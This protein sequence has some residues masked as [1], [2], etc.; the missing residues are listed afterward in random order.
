MNAI[1]RGDLVIHYTVSPGDP[2]DRFCPGE[3][4]HVEDLAV[5]WR[6]REL[7]NVS[8]RNVERIETEIMSFEADRW[9]AHNGW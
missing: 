1:E 5:E 7:V 6:G 2:G 8:N 9:E 3:P 4:P